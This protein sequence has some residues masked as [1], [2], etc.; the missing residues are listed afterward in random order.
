M[1]RFMAE[2][3]EGLYVE[4]HETRAIPGQLIRGEFRKAGG[5]VA[6]LGRMG[7]LAVLWVLPGGAVIS[8]VVVKFFK[9]I[10]PSAF[11]GES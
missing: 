4:W 3:K 11:R 7:V 10:R 9:R 2:L 5:Q 6:D 1:N 8:G